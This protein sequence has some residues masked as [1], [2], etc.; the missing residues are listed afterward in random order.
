MKQIW[1]HV[2]ANG[3]AQHIYE[4][5]PTLAQMQEAVGGLIEY[6]PTTGPH[7]VP[8]PSANGGTPVWGECVE[9]I[10]NEEGRLRGFG[11]NAIATF[12][13]YGNGMRIPPGCAPLV[14]PAILKCI[15]REE[16]E[17]ASLDEFIKAALNDDEMR[18]FKQVDGMMPSHVLHMA[19]RD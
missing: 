7:R 3:R 17:N 11:I 5:K 6:A 13:C 12:A 8:V 9:V 4:E 14:G 16:A 15:I 10:V 19:R 1:I 2:D 18:V